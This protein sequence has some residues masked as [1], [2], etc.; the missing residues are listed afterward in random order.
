MKNRFLNKVLAI[1]GAAITLACTL[2]LPSY[3]A[4]LTIIDAEGQYEVETEA[5]LRIP[6]DT[7]NWTFVGFVKDADYKEFRALYDSGVNAYAVDYIYDGSTPLEVGATMYA[8]YVQ[9]ETIILQPVDVDTNEV[10]TYNA[11]CTPF[12][13]AAVTG[14]GVLEEMSHTQQEALDD[15]RGLANE[16]W[17]VLPEFLKA[18]TGEAYYVVDNMDLSKLYTDPE[19]TQEFDVNTPF[20][21]NMTI[22]APIG[23]SKNPNAV[24][25]SGITVST[26]GSAVAQTGSTTGTGKVQ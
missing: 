17:T 23:V 26:T 2:P 8:L 18:A 10:L 15:S 24:V 13:E 21:N 16:F 19:F 12:Y 7:D 20:T 25:P 4:A 1:A 14:E 5:D 6:E 11:P 9:T 3:A 22:Y